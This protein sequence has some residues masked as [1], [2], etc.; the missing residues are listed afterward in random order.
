MCEIADSDLI[1]IF[2]CVEAKFV[3]EVRSFKQSKQ[4]AIDEDDTPILYAITTLASD[5]LL[6]N[7]SRAAVFSNQ[8]TPILFL[9]VDLATDADVETGNS[10]VRLTIEVFREFSAS[11]QGRRYVLQFSV[12]SA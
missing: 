7:R 8:F 10:Y 12:V 11:M 3:S 5:L 9:L 6:Y 4:Q 1:H 2:K